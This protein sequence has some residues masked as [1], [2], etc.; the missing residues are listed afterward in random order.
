[1][2][3]WFDVDDLVAYFN[4]N[5]RPSG[6]QRLCFQV[7]QEVWAQA[8]ASGAIRFCRHNLHYTGL[9]EI[10]WP[11][12]ERMIRQVSI[13]SEPDKAALI[14]PPRLAEEPPPPQR[15]AGAPARWLAKAVLNDDLRNRMGIAYYRAPTRVEGL[16]R[17]AGAALTYFGWLTSARV[18]IEANEID[19]PEAE[20]DLRDGDM[21]VALGSIWDPRFFTLLPQLREGRDLRFATMFYDLI[22]LALPQFTDPP[23]ASL[24]RNW[25]FTI[26]PQADVLFTIS[27]ASARDLEVAMREAGRVIPAPVILPVGATP[28][29]VATALARPAAPFVL[30][31]STI[32][33]RKNH[34]LMLAVW[35]NL[36]AE[37]PTEAVPNLVF[38][39]R[40]I[41]NIAA[42]FDGS[43]RHPAL[44]KKFWIIAEPDDEQLAGLYRQCLFTVFPSFYEGWGLPVTESFSFGKTV[45]ASNRGSLPEA[46]QDF[47][48]YY[49]PGNLAEAT[50]VIRG[51][52][53]HP[54]RVAAF[55]AA[56][57]ARFDPPSWSD[58]AAAL[59]AVLHQESEPIK[60]LPETVA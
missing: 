59:L 37:L 17:A 24:F 4:A 60:R 36:L 42:T 23:L 45:A 19:A 44:R 9:V 7:Y 5:R 40:V 53:E 2:T 22:P 27:R 14:K 50:S 33:P 56:I 39:G 3:V 35:E 41:G 54:E 43:M 57:A 32:E 52:I 20:P 28:P 21:L 30:F 46:G 16:R 15:R 31:V 6:I 8:G 34:A 38:A 12:L 51:L 26:V 47:C 10:K 13:E 48:A 49:D 29:T 55:E 18:P 11:T 58:T 25:L 1:M